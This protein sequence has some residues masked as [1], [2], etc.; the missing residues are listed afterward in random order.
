MRSAMP[1]RLMAPGSASFDLRSLGWRS[2]QELCRAV[3]RTVWPSRRMRSLIP[4][5]ADIAV[6]F[7][8]T[9]HNLPDL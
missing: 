5:T 8:S 9:W 1:D 7:Y 2:F 4:A 3:V 6:P